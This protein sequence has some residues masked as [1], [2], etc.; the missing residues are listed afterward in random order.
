MMMQDNAT[1]NCGT[2]IS[3]LPPYELCL[4]ITQLT[5]YTWLTRG[6]FLQVQL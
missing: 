5:F 4:R 6:D 1:N 3:G 2:Y